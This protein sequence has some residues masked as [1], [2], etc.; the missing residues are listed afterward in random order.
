MC[1]CTIAVAG[2]HTDQKQH[3]DVT[4]HDIATLRHCANVL[5]RDAATKQRNP[6]LN[7]CHADA[8]GILVT[9]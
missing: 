8:N 6:V 5:Q 4:Q 2:N 1:N 9:R 7:Y 3:A